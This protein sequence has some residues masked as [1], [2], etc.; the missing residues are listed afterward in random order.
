MGIFWDENVTFAKQTTFLYH[1]ANMSSDSMSNLPPT[2]SQEHQTRMPT[3]RGTSYYSSSSPGCLRG[4]L[5][6]AH[7]TNPRG[8]PP[9][10]AV[11]PPPLA[12]TAPPPSSPVRASRRARLRR[13]PPP[14]LAVVIP[15]WGGFGARWTRSSGSS[16]QQNENGMR[17]S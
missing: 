12:T 1:S 9:P 14:R 13:R 17:Y 4:P 3:V 15:F 2:M 6:P 11:L 10:L 7:G 16:I 5:P 8:P